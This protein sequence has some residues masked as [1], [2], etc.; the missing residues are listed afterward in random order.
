MFDNC[1]FD[2]SEGIINTTKKPGTQSKKFKSNDELLN[3]I[4]IHEN[5]VCLNVHK[6]KMSKLPL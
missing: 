5:K 2:V 6:Q 3:L 4:A 1:Q